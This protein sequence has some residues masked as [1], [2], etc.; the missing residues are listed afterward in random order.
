MGALARRAWGWVCLVPCAALL[1][2]GGLQWGLSTLAIKNDSAPGVMVDVD[3]QRM[4]LLCSGSGSPAVI[5]E[6][7]IPSSSLAWDEV[8]PEVASMTRVCSYDRKGY[9]WSEPS[10]GPRTVG[11]IAEELRSLL[12]NAEV[13]PPYVLVGHSFGGL[14]VQRFA[15]EFPDDVVAV[16]LVDSSH[17]DQV[18]ATLELDQM[19]SLGFWLRI[20]A[21]VGLHRPFLPI[22]AGSPDTR[23]STVR[24]MEK[25]LLM[26]TRSVR[27]VASE[28]TSMRESLQ[29]VAETKLELGQT[30]LFVLSEGRRRA[31]FWLEMQEDL[32][33]LSEASEWQVAEGTGHYIHHEQPQLVVEAIRRAVVLARTEVSGL[34]GAYSHSGEPA[35]FA[36]TPR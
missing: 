19:T 9:A 28:V 5:L 35:S 23:T 30:P 11:R 2:G 4:H 22:P 6:A 3:G 20:L 8:M 25:D 26:T 18:H 7:G 33:R 27:A 13:R 10:P 29:D 21:P 16:V 17:P 12:R 14:V 1:L 34:S 15:G 31:D 24:A 32:T 36:R